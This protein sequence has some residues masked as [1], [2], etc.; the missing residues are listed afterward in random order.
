MPLDPRIVERL[1]LLEGVGRSGPAAARADA[2]FTED[3]PWSEPSGIDI[4]DLVVPGP[5]GTIPI[6]RYA[7]RAYESALLWV[8]GGGFSY[9]GLDMPESHVVAAELAA[10]AK[11]LVVT[12]DYRLARPEQRYPIPMDDVIAAWQ[13]LGIEYPNARRALGGASAGA[14]L[15]LACARSEPENVATLLLAYP[16][17]HFPV[18]AL[19]DATAA[20]MRGL[21]SRLR[22]TPPVIDDMVLSY[23][24]R[25]HSLPELALPAAAPIVA[26]HPETYVLTSEYDDLRPSGDLL[27]RQLADA[28]IRVH[29]R[30]ELGVLHGHLNRHPGA[31][32]VDG[33]LDWFASALR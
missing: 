28:C 26:T 18:P 31:P 33:S 17:V 23:V 19:D 4:S 21:P 2:A 8:H 13:W 24:G 20:V 10:R 5:H 14:A 25:L 30:R 12:V 7:P 29:E 32:G 22:F 27:V 15:A 11:A 3:G 6:R 9:G 16:F 1:P